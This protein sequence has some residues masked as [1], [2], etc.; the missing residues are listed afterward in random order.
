[1]ARKMQN[2]KVLTLKWICVVHVDPG[3]LQAPLKKISRPA[4]IFFFSNTDFDKITTCLFLGVIFF[5]IGP[6]V[7]TILFRGPNLNE[8]PH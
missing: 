8:Q 7:S 3:Q 1:M 5:R 6:P 2:L 4:K